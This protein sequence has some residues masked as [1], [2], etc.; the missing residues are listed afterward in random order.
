MKINFL[1]IVPSQANFVMCEVLAPH[2][3]RELTVKLLERNILVKE[4]SA[5]NELCN[6]EYV[7]IAV[8]NEKDNERL[9]AVL[10]GI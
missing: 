1:R 8:G 3:G 5:Y 2:T 6:R 9:I 4:L 7:R 10:R